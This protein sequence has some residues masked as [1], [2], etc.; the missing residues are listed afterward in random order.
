M[1]RR[2]SRGTWFPTIGNLVNAETDAVAS[3]RSFV[4]TLPP[5]VPEIVSAITPLTF[6]TPREGDALVA[7]EDSL[8]DIVGSDYVLQRIVG[9]I[10][11][12]RLSEIAETGRDT[13]P[14]V[15]FS[16]GFFVARA[17]DD[18]SGG[19][20]QFPIGSATQTEITSNYSPLDIDTMREP[21]IWR[22]TW[23][24]GSAGQG[25]QFNSQIGGV[26]SDVPATRPEVW[27]SPASTT[28]YG[29]VADGPHIDS[30]VKRRV[31]Q[32]NRLWFIV[33]ATPFPLESSP[34]GLLQVKGYLDYRI[35]GS[36]RK[37]RQSSA[38]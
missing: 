36:L 29:S 32:D 35:F 16:C 7:G 4:I 18:A 22:R 9:K 12:Y 3:G 17:N 15:L 11:A 6:D 38:F 20:D 34:V 19:G 33:S 26:A 28:L 24:L 23:L 14:A 31:T 10:F 1:R 30:R 5:A 27:T 25:Q 8:A 21:W 37:A 13:N 2:R